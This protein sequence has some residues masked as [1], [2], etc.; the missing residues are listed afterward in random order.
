LITPIAAAASHA[1]SRFQPRLRAA[2]FRR[3][4]LAG[5][6]ATPMSH[7][8]PDC[9]EHYDEPMS[10]AI[11]QIFAIDAALLSSP[12]FASAAAA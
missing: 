5:E 9:I 8:Q 2:D 12:Y 7:Y 1:F 4:Y 10:R 6:A 3:Q 11:R